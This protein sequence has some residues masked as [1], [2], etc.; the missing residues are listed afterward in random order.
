MERAVMD[1]TIV[2]AVREDGWVECRP[3]DGND[4]Q[5]R[6]A[7]NKFVQDKKS[8]SC[9]W[10]LTY[11]KAAVAVPECQ[12][13]EASTYTPEDYRK[14]STGRFYPQV[15][16]LSYSLKT[17][18]IY[19]ED[20]GLNKGEWEYLMRPEQI[21]GVQSGLVLW[22]RRHGGPHKSQLEIIEDARARGLTVVESL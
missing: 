4:M 11:L 21:R 13:V 16:V 14:R 18:K 22:D 19:A 7:T 9:L 17:A 8:D 2:V 3:V 5:S 6:E 15:Y 20:Q 1:V 10:Q 12:V